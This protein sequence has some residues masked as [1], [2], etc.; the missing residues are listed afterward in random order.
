LDVAALAAVA[1]LLVVVLVP[2]PENAGATADAAVAENAGAPEDAGAEVG[3]L[4]RIRAHILR[5]GTEETG[6][7][8]LVTAIYLGYRAWDTVGETIVLLL[9]VSGIA[10]LVRTKE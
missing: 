4:G 8:N 9:A 5:Q 6:A 10:W 7:L 2:G 1:L 3:G